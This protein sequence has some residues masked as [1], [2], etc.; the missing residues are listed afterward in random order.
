MERSATGYSEV[1][2]GSIY[3]TLTG[4]AIVYVCLLTF[5]IQFESV[6]QAN[7]RLDY[8]AGPK[9]AVKPGLDESWA[10]GLNAAAQSG[11]IF[12]KDLV[13]TYGPLGFLMSPRPLGR[14]LQWA[15]CFA[16][17]I[18]A[19]FAA[20]LAAMAA[21]ARTRRGF[22]LF[23]AGSAAA[24]L[25]G[26]WD[27]YLYRLVMGLCCIAACLTSP[28][29]IAA[30]ILAGVLMPVLLMIKFSIGLTALS[31][32]AA[33]TLILIVRG[34]AWRKIIVLW[35]SAALSLTLW[36]FFLFGNAG[37]FVRWL[38][39]S[40]EIASG[41]GAALSFAGPT[42]EALAGILLL[43]V[44]LLSAVFLDGA[45][46]I[47]SLLFAVPAVLA[48]KHGFVGHT[49][50][51]TGYSTFMAAI[52]SI[53]FLFVQ[54]RAEWRVA[55]LVGALTFAAALYKGL[56]LIAWPPITL[57]DLGRQLSGQVAMQAL[58]NG[59][60]WKRLTLEL[61]A[62]STRH[63]APEVLP[64]R[65]K[66]G[67][68]ASESGVDV[69]P[70]ELSYL[71]AND[72]SWRPSL[73]LQHY[74]TDTHS[75][76]QA[77]ADRLGT[78][79][80]PSALLM[81]FTGMQG[82]QMLL[83]TPQVFRRILAD[84]EPVE[85]DY[86]RNLLWVRRRAGGPASIAN[87]RIAGPTRIRF[88]DWVTPPAC[89]G[90]LFAEFFMRPNALGFV[91]QILWKTPPVY[92]RLE[93]EDA[94]TAEFRMLPAMASGGLLINYLPRTLQDL[95]DLM[96]G[97]AFHR[98]RR[99]QFF[100]P[101]TS[102]YRQEFDVAWIADKSAFVDYSHAERHSL[103]EVVSVVPDSSG[104][105]E[106]MFTIT[107]R[108]GGGYR[109]LKFVKFIANDTNSAAGACY[110]RYQLDARILWLMDGEN[111][112]TGVSMLGSPQVFENTKCS[113]NLAESWQEFR[114]DSLILHL[115]IAL[116]PGVRSAQRIFAT[117]VDEN[118]R[119][120]E[121]KEFA[122][123]LPAAGEVREDPWTFPPGPPSLSVEPTKLKDESKYILKVRAIDLN[124]AENIDAVEV[125]VNNAVDGRHSCLFRYDTRA[126]T[127]SLRDDAGSSY[128]AP[129]Q[130]G[131]TKQLS[132]SYCAIAA[133]DPPLV[134]GRYDVYLSFEFSPT[135]RMLKKGV[136]AIFLAAVDR[137]G[138]RQNWRAYAVLPR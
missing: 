35:L 65:W 132:N 120:S 137:Q 10:W 3:R 133:P 17:C 125:M 55:S 119:A 61:E 136:V 130:L 67:L 73:V 29:A 89:S 129:L 49:G 116:K 12:G 32:M 24:A 30:C 69:Y 39:L 84:Y 122:P 81:E 59:W 46:R 88:G 115:D 64:A 9:G 53:I 28:F 33:A 90:K 63:L 27:E 38:A 112:S 41:Y 19:I 100:G 95:A 11:Y 138:L 77:M 72:L 124:G 57:A 117:A 98:V 82:R 103:P 131:S 106:R 113:V 96:Q 91:R 102:S 104:R 16:V 34:R 118:L 114:G 20:L 60:N 126:K 134:K 54:T 111:S 92:L 45:A 87:A 15:S 44:L 58:Q 40:W 94:S 42:D 123:W 2:G 121:V 4:L 99:F 80:G 23:L 86:S 127:V 85:T 70:W 110:L 128:S 22:L 97:H 75:L 101:G 109:R 31:M 18:R 51:A 8:I 76:D 66:A 47:P 52:A 14:N 83:D 135:E 78:Q 105:Q 108:A 6:D 1:K 21:A 25:M 43:A 56:F 93:Y 26:L 5:S 50:M 107:A 48:L 74:Q 7:A 62:E 13:F 68:K 36:V 79:N 71:P 37:Y